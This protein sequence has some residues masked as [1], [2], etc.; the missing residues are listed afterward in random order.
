MS[1]IIDRRLNDK[2]KSTVN[3]QR[4][5]RRY[6]KHIREAVND[7]VNRRSIQDME[8]GERINIPRKDLSEPIFHHGLGGQ[9]SIVHPETR[10]FTRATESCARRAEV[11]RELAMARPA[12]REKAKMAS[13]LKSTNRS[14]STSCSKIWNYPTW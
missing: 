3:R 4:F 6:R 5:L 8:Q 2:R 12:T 11:V 14:F 10:S 7:A 13:P 1:Y 9:R